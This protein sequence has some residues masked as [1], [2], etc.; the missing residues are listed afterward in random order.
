M[1]KTFKI[2][3]V[4][5]GTTKE[6]SFGTIKLTSLQSISISEEADSS[7]VMGSDGAVY[8]KKHIMRGLSNTIT[9]ETTDVSLANTIHM[10]LPAAALVVQ[11][12]EATDGVGNSGPITITAANA[13]VESVSDAVINHNGDGTMSV[14]FRCTAPDGSTRPIAFS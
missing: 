3:L 14:T 6:S 1:M 9:I 8:A 12:V 2:N 11:G 4:T 10:A 5:S 13:T 7:T